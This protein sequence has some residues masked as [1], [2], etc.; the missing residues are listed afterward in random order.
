MWEWTEG[1]LKVAEFLVDADTMKGCC[2]YGLYTLLRDFLR[3]LQKSLPFLGQFVVFLQS[4]SPLLFFTYSS[5]SEMKI[6]VVDVNHF[7][8]QIADKYFS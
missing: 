6:A 3:M 2:E 8:N 4:F 1:D 5:S 7:I